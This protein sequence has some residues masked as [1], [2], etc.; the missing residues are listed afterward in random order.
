MIFSIFIMRAMYVLQR[1]WICGTSEH[2]NNQSGSSTRTITSKYKHKQAPYSACQLA[3]VATDLQN[4]SY[5]GTR[6]QTHWK[7]KPVSTRSAYYKNHQSANDHDPNLHSS[8]TPSNKWLLGLCHT[9]FT[10]VAILNHKFIDIQD[11]LDISNISDILSYIQKVLIATGAIGQKGLHAI[12]AQDFFECEKH[13]T[14]GQCHTSNTKS[15]NL[16][17]SVHQIE[18][19]MLHVPICHCIYCK[20]I[21]DAKQTSPS[22]EQGMSR[23]CADKG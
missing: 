23:M 9:D 17:M 5:L 18:C 6:Q 20:T 12:W 15:A 3:M 11:F 1:T 14:N 10:W 19:N 8:N 7:A 2:S 13:A 21:G 16:S 4:S 22:G